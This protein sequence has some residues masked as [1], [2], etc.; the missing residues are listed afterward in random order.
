MRGC[1]VP[2][3]SRNGGRQITASQ[4]ARPGPAAQGRPRAD[5]Q[6]SPGAHAAHKSVHSWWDRVGTGFRDSIRGKG[7]SH[8]GTTRGSKV[9]GNCP[10]GRSMPA[11]FIL[12]ENRRMKRVGS[13]RGDCPRGHSTAP[14]TAGHTGPRSR[15]TLQPRHLTEARAGSCPRAQVPRGE[16]SRV[17]QGSFLSEAHRALHRALRPPRPARGVGLQGSRDSSGNPGDQR[18]RGHRKGGRVPDH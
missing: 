12:K 10:R 1:P 11:F 16:G 13:G 18:Q 6:R 3:G 2:L 8:W 4:P 17:A 14:D 7:R 9:P 5:P 15:G